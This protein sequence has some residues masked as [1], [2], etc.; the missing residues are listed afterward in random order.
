MFKKTN[1]EIKEWYGF[2]FFEKSFPYLYKKFIKKYY[3]KKL[4]LNIKGYNYL[5]SKNQLGI[6]RKTKLEIAGMP[7]ILNSIP[8]DLKILFQ[9]A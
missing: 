4:I 5:K 2:N 7:L 6:G 8:C 1:L 3:L 9:L